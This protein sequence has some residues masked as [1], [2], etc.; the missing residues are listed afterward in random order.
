DIYLLRD[1]FEWLNSSYGALHDPSVLFQ[2][3]NNFFRPMVKLSYLFNY[4][5][6]HTQGT[7]YSLTT[8]IIHLVN[9]LLLYIL[10]YRV[11]RESA[12]TGEP[13]SGGGL[14]P[15]HSVAIAATIAL[16]FG[17][18]P[19]YSE[20]SLWAA[21][22]PDSILLVFILAVL[23]R[24]TAGP[25]NPAKPGVVPPVVS[26]GGWVIILLLT[27][28][29]AGSK[30]TWIL[31]PFLAL[32]FL[33]ILKGQT[34]KNALKT[35]SPL[36][37][38]LALYMGYFIGLPLLAG[39][40]SPTN[41]AEVSLTNMVKKFSFLIFKYAGM[42]ELVPSSVWQYVLLV[43]IGGTVIYMCIRRKN[44]LALWGMTWMV[45]TISISLP[46]YY[47]PAR[48]NYLPLLGFWVMIVAFTS[49]EISELVKN[50]SDGKPLLKPRL[51]FFVAG[52]LLLFVLSYQVIML[53][54]EIKDYRMQGEPQKSLVQ[55]YN[56]VKE[57]LPHNE[58][59][60]FV[61]LGK[62]KAVSESAES[63]MGYRKLLFDREKAIWQLVFIAPLANFA[64]APFK[65]T[66]EL[67]PDSGLD[68]VF[69]GEFTVLV[70]TDD[71]FFISDFHKSQL[72]EYYGKHGSLPWKVQAIRF[73]PVGQK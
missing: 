54:W 53:Q 4:L 8:I 48:Y 67:V 55:M 38:M 61:D 58:P 43:I 73:V 3:I 35:A 14:K 41:Y 21:G 32:S 19:M 47:A 28:C 20:S 64:G 70:F 45:I 15:G 29:A 33:W 68:E 59:I 52:M 7:L 37:I 34:F 10:I 44:R 69:A 49:R 12:V 6:V 24:F 36:F 17:T 11:F 51:V 66:M 57:R 46:I 40:A 60:V 71:A 25:I 63:I 22:R 5:L 26:G 13:P 1:D 42:G 18:S 31:L 30:E 65:E 2:R 62:R 50:R 56:M 16:T 9:V 27:L 72:R 23:I 39:K